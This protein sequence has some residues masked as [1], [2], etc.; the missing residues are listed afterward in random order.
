MSRDHLREFLQ[1]TLKQ[2][3]SLIDDVVI[4]QLRASMHE[5]GKLQ[6]LLPPKAK[7]MED[8]SPA[9]QVPPDSLEHAPLPMS[10]K[11]KTIIEE[12]KGCHPTP[13]ALQGPAGASASVPE[14]TIPLGFNVQADSKEDTKEGKGSH[15]ESSIQSWGLGSS[16][17][18]SGSGGTARLS[19][20]QCSW[21]DE[22][23]P[24]WCWTSLIKLNMTFKDDE[25]SSDNE[26]YSGLEELEEE[27]EEEEDR[28]SESP[29]SPWPK[30]LQDL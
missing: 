15:G 16:A 19:G 7:P 24:L 5:L 29:P 18:A 4:R 17:G 1:V 25:S 3:W 30:L 9:L 28:A 22:P 12:S 14:E 2:V 23:G 6:C 20:H 21:L 11:L 13:S 26:D 10:L 27:E 8:C